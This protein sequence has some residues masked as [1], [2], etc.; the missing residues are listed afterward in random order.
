MAVNLFENFLAKAPK[1]VLE[2]EINNN[3][4]RDAIVHRINAWKDP[5]G[6]K[7]LQLEMNRLQDDEAEIK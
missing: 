4:I 2:L 3:K 7:Q 1:R 6:V 5:E